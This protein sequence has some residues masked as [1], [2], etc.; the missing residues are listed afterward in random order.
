MPADLLPE[1]LKLFDGLE[2]LGRMLFCVLGTCWEWELDG[3]DDHVL[4][5]FGL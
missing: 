2:P 4:F 5:C 3:L 1:D